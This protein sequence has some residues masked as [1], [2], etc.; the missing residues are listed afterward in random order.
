MDH[1]RQDPSEQQ[2]LWPPLVDPLAVAM[3]SMVLVPLTLAVACV[4]AVDGADARGDAV[5]LVAHTLAAP[6]SSPRPEQPLVLTSAL[7]PT[8]NTAPPRPLP[9]KWNMSGITFTGGRYCPEV[10]MGGNESFASLQRLASTGANWVS[11]VV[12]WYQWNISST[13]IFPLYNASLVNDTTSHYY[14][15]VTLSNAE[16]TA[17]IKHAHALGLSVMLKPHIDL[18]RDNKPDGRFWR[19][20]IGGCPATDWRPPPAG[21]EPF[22]EAQWDVWFE[23][24][25]S[26]IMGYAR[27]AES[28]NVDM[29]SLNCE[30]YCANRQSQRWRTLASRVRGAFS[31]AL[32]VSQIV[33]HEE[34]ITWWDAVDVIGID[35]YYKIAGDTLEEMVAGWADAIALGEKL[36]TQYDRPIAYTEIGYCSGKCSRTH[37]PTKAN[38]ERHAMQYTAVFE[39]FRGVR[40]FAGCFWWN[41]NTDPGAFD[42]DDCLTPQQKP[43]EDVLR[44]YYRAR[45]PKPLPVG[46]AVCAGAGKCTC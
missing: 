15:F 36:H 16:V 45:S 5:G 32:T 24:Y 12:T 37:T 42:G 35:A 26:F 7:P 43:A 38:Y 31:K 17:A 4:A 20:T 1:N 39:A 14:T 11:I 25:A 28:L 29:L 44:T 46:V 40:W 22:T 9:D 30:L 10:A 34:E 33:G 2:P 27:M 18:L 3:A 21:V 19:G 8:T 23:S 6:P 13:E 41:W